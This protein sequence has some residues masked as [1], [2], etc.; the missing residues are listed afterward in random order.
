VTTGSVVSCVNGKERDESGGDVRP[1]RGM[2]ANRAV[3][4][5][6][7]RL[8]QTDRQGPG[9]APRVAALAPSSPPQTASSSA[10]PNWLL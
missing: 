3:F 6:I 10:S 2:T 7:V 9:R 1:A 8:A 4:G 5:P